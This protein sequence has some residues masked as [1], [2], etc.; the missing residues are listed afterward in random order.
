MTMPPSDPND[1]QNSSNI[2][3]DDDA[4]WA[5]LLCEETASGN[6]PMMPRGAA[7]PANP[8][9]PTTVSVRL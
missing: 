7:D 1:N 9:L 2:S 5:S 3:S 6:S 8:Q 4:F